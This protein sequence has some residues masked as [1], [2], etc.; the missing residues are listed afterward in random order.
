MPKL[1]SILA[2]LGM[3]VG[4]VGLLATR[5]LLSPAPLVIALQLV[6]L[7]LAVWARVTFGKRSFHVA[8][9]P[10]EGGLVTDGPYQYIRHPIYAAVCL[11]TWAGL[12]A[13]W[14]WTAVAFGG[15]VVCC[16]VTR[17][18]AEEALV[19][20][21]YPEYKQYAARTWRMIPFLF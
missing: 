21:R 16:A 4:V 17:I 5:N 20:T 12:V 7:L 19:A 14:S 13:H 6:A 3:V 10:T 15:L 2:Y 1:L 8:A 18:F 11:F 9:N